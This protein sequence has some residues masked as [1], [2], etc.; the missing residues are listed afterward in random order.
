[1]RCRRGTTASDNRL[2]LDVEVRLVRGRALPQQI[3]VEPGVSESV[4]RAASATVARVVL[5]KPAHPLLG[6]VIELTSE[7]VID[8]AN[9]CDRVGDEGG[10]LHIDDTVG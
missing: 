3:W 9:R 10:E 8:L 4:T 2:G 5:E 1:M 6:E 7:R